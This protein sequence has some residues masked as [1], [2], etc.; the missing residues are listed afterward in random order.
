MRAWI[1]VQGTQRDEDVVKEGVISG[2]PVPPGSNA[3]CRCFACSFRETLELPIHRGLL[4]I[5]F[6]DI[7]SDDILP[8]P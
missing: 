8:P 5:T 3:Q 6:H 7:T 4:H 1:L 2:K